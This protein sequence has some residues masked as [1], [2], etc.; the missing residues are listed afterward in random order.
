MIA[1]KIADIITQPERYSYEHIEAED[2]KRGFVE[3]FDDYY[4]KWERHEFTVDNDAVAIKCEYIVN[5]ADKGDVKHVVVIAHGLTANRMADL[6]YGKMFYDIGYNL[7]IFDERR[8]GESGGEYCSLGQN[9]PEDIKLICKKAREIFGSNCFLGLHGESMGAAS[10]LGTLDTL[11]PDFV[12]ADCPFSDLGLL[13]SDLAKAKLG[14]FGNYIFK[15]ARKLCKRFDGYDF[16]TVKPFEKMRDSEVP[17]CFFHGSEDTLIDCKHSKYMY[18]LCKNPLSE[19]H[20][21][22]GANHAL[23]VAVDSE[24]YRKQMT[25]FIKKVEET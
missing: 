10:V 2:R 11:R 16:T 23:S 22:E 14:F 5:P 18:S 8:H 17:I 4:T 20:I 3:C 19:L 12:I 6:K 13:V 21:V 7:V 1:R 9:E 15:R 24:E 25:A